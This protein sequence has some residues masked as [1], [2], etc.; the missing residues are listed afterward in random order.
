M[1]FAGGGSAGHVY[2]ALVLA[3]EIL[4][5]KSG[6]Q[7]SFVGTKSGLEATLV[8]KAGFHLETLPVAGLLRM[9]RLS[10]MKTLVIMPLAFLK[11]I[12]IL[13]RTRPHIVLG[14]GGFAAGPFVLV[15]SFFVKKTF[16]WEPNAHPGFT[17][18]LL[19][20][21]VS[22][23]FVVFDAARSLLH[24]RTIVTAGLPLRSE[25]KYQARPS[26]QPF[27]VLVFG[28]SQGARPIN[29][30]M[31]EVYQRS[32]L[33]LKGVE[34][35]HQTGRL[36]FVEVSEKLKG[37][38]GVRVLE[39]IDS[40][41]DFYAW[42]DLVICRGGVGTVSEVIA[43]QK[44]AVV[45]PLPTAAENHQQANAAVLVRAGAG[46]MILQRDLTADCLI[47]T[48]AELRNN[49]NLIA[50]IEKATVSLQ[51]PNGASKIVDCLLSGEAPEGTAEE[52]PK[53]NREKD[54]KE[55]VSSR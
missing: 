21:F 6:A 13:L 36:D 35:V 55:K 32:D 43:C 29:R 52:N 38:E 37:V 14:M 7:I 18:R 49:P 25:M 48:L 1:I 9:G 50:S 28:G 46:K 16:I 51:N 17:N 10:Q 23:A 41:A 19:S 54:P 40:M 3:Q 33:R 26:G 30:A 22:R 15:S 31:V 11:C 53:E 5:R 27:R 47:E 45:I 2:P 4:K 24:S 42:A 8:P 44:A 34:F 39:Y 12:L 20:H